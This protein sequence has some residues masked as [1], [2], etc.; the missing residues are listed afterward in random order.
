MICALP[1]CQ[2]EIPQSRFDNGAKYCCDRHRKRAVDRRFRHGSAEA[3]SAVVSDTDDKLVQLLK[4]HGVEAGAIDS[5]KAIKITDWEGLAKGEEGE[6]TRVVPLSSTS[7]VIHPSWATGPKWELPHPPAPIKVSVPKAAP[8]LLKGWKTA[9][10]LPDAQY[11]YRRDIFD[12]SLDPF[13]DERAIDV[14]LQIAE[15]ERPALTIVLGDYLDFAYFGKYQQEPTF[16]LTV[17]ASLDASYADLV[18]FRALTAEM[19]FLE[20]NHDL[21]L[22]NMIIDN[23][24]AAFGVKKAGSTRDDWPV[25]SVPNLLRMDELDIEYVGAYPAGATYIND[26]LACIHGK[27]V[28][29]ANKSAASI[30]VEDERVSVIFGHTHHHEMRHKT[31]PTRHSPKFSVAYSP[32]CLCRI[33]G[34]VPSTK[35]GIDPMGRPAKSWEDWQQGVAIVRY[36]EGDGRFHIEPIEIIEGKAIHDKQEFVS[37]VEP[38]WAT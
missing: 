30:V 15:V 29:N 34:A 38:E 1:E 31:R 2:E 16:A 35:S 7:V 10:I 9:L 4:A 36:Q 19:R 32:G 24:K 25:L 21:R 22:Q 27:R 33:D 37:R 18:Q 20:G 26:N 14:A 12:G 8:S 13:H 23:A 28:G 6:A 11:G 17:Q 5:I 3:R